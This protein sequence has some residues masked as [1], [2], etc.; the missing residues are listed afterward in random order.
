MLISFPKRGSLMNGR[1]RAGLIYFSSIFWKRIKKGGLS[2][3]RLCHI[4][5]FYQDQSFSWQDVFIQGARAF[6]AFV[7]SSD[8]LFDRLGSKDPGR[9]RKSPHWCIKIPHLLNPIEI[10]RILNHLAWFLR[11]HLRSNEGKNSS[12]QTLECGSF[13]AQAL[14]NYQFQ[15][16]GVDLPEPAALVRWLLIRIAEET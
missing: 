12:L 15:P 5:N 10:K 3:S 7:I 16:V 4:K 11:H 2:K 1:W 13:C 14:K 8:P 9:C 6:S